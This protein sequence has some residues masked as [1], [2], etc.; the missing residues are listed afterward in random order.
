MQSS[1]DDEQ[2][3]NRPRRRHKERNVL[4]WIIVPTLAGSLFG[5][6]FFNAAAGAAIFGLPVLAASLLTRR[7][8]GRAANDREMGIADR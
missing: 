4:L 1:H 2:S 3:S 5:I 6:A 7:L 8:I